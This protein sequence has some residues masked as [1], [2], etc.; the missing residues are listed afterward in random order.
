VD[1]RT[2]GRVLW[3]FRLIVLAGL[4]LALGLSFLSAARVNFKGGRPTLVYRHPPT[5]SS[6]STIF[7][8]QQ[9]FALGRAVYPNVSVASGGSTQYV[10]V[11]SDPSRFS[12]YSTYY[13]TIATSDDVRRLMLRDGPLPG[14]IFASPDTVLATG[15]A[16][17]FLTISGV[18]T[19]PNRAV[20][21]ARR[22]I[23]ALQE[24]V[25]LQ[26]D[27][28]RVP[29]D[30]RIVLKVLN[31]PVGATEIARPSKTRPIVI[32]LAV[33]MAVLGLAFVLENLRPRVRAVE[34]SARAVADAAR[35]TA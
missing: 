1:L 32:F 30:Q 6:A 17:P 7:I 16:L 29:A 23:K 28:T 34:A 19:T 25:K 20:E 10:P 33:M 11:L 27:A 31:Q 2:Y 12:N 35:R 5:W 24:Y 4:V 15:T 9:G 8:T 26:Q 18:A 21:A 22:G 3:R 13:A 14:A